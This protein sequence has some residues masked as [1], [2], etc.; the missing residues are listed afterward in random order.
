MSK[1]LKEFRMEKGYFF[2][3]LSNLSGV[4]VSYIKGLKNASKRNPSLDIVH[5]IARVLNKD[6]VDICYFN[7]SIWIMDFERIFYFISPMFFGGS[8]LEQ[9]RKRWFK[10]SFY[11]FSELFFCFQ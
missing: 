4:F 3:E 11:P 2:N 10:I 9:F 1:R 7:W 6:I 8:I 5:K